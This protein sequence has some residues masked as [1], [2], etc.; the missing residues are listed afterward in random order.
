MTNGDADTGVLALSLTD[1]E[2]VFTVTIGEQ[3]AVQTGPADATDLE[4]TG[5]AVEVLEALSIRRALGQV[6]DPDVAWMV[7]GLATQFDASR[8]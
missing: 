4:L 7:D 5:N 6:I 3:I 2:T 8:G 1:P